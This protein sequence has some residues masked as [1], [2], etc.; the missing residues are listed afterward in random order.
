[1]SM[2]VVTLIV[3]I[4]NFKD[5]SLPSLFQVYAKYEQFDLTNRKDFIKSTVKEVSISQYQSI[6]SQKPQ[7]NRHDE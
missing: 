6:K 2:L 3:R 5:L 1:M 4:Y 7:L